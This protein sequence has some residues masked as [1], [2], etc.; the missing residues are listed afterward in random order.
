MELILI[1]AASTGMSRL[2]ESE[3]KS[4]LQWGGLTLLACLLCWLFI[5]LPFL[6]VGLG[7]VAV[8][9]LMTATNKVGY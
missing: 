8:F 6:R 9:I 5:P 1:I 2:A 3:G 7:C 4:G